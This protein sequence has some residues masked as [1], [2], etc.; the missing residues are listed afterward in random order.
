MDSTLLVIVIATFALG[1]ASQVLADKYGIPSIIF[2]IIAG[3]LAGPEVLGIIQPEA[4]GEGLQVIVGLAVAIIVFEGAFHLKISK[5]KKAQSEA[6]RLGTIGAIISGL[7]TAIAA[8][9]TLDVSWDIAFLI[10]ALLIATGPTVIKPILEVVSV[11]KK[12]EAALET[13]G[14]VNDVSAAILALVVYEFVVLQSTSYGELATQFFTRWG[15]GVFIGIATALAAWYTINNLNLRISKEAQDARI[16]VLG[17]AL[18]SYGAAELIITEAGIAAAAT[19]GILLGNLEMPYKKEVKEFEDAISVIVLTFV[20]IA[21]TA[22]L[23]FESLLTLGIGGLIFVLLVTLLIRPIMVFA[24]TTGSRFSN[25]EKLYLS[26]IGPRGIIP[27]SVATLFALELQ[28]M[29]RN[30][31]AAA[32]V[33]SVFLVIVATSF[34]EGGLAKIAAKKLNVIPMHTIIVGAGE[35]GR[36]LAQKLEQRG[37]EIVIIEKNPEEAEKA[38]SLGFKVIEGDARKEE[39]LREASNGKAEIIAI[40]THDDDVN[41]VVSQIAKSKLDIDKIVSRVND[42]DN[43]E[44]MKDLEVS[45]ITSPEAVAD[46]FDNM[47]ET[48]K[49]WK[50]LTQHRDQLEVVEK[51]IT[52]KQ[53]VKEFEKQLTN[54]AAMTLITRN[55]EPIQPEETTHL[56]QGDIVTIIGR[57]KI[58][59]KMKNL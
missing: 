42:P 53:K 44:A 3:V 8:Y 4:F 7:L 40:M 54:G 10:G 55:G 29:G 57:K 5:L 13:E 15:T 21:L 31:E 14:I 1:I 12:V 56:E 26:M 22:L 32:I 59:R 24:S 47:I 18:I 35:A 2:L 45:T 25:R 34:I 36:E 51:E 19:A 37:E 46:A 16:I 43:A 33:G 58:L 52:Q 48:P 50:Q 38:R 23:S 41:I 28:N 11:R 20:F 6:L 39:T 17:T 49:I 27:A 9:Y 30:E